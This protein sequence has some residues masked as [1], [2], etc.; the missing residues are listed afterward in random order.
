VAVD[1][2]PVPVPV[3]AS[4]VG[5]GADLVDLDRFRRVMARTPSI[6]ER[7]FTEQEQAYARSRRDPCERFGAR[8]AAKEATM[9]VLGVGLGQVRFRDL[10]VTR[11]A[12]GQPVLELHGPAAEL[13]RGQGITGWLVSLTHTAHLAQAVVV[14]LG[15][16]PP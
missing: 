3:G 2:P 5:V 14:G 1:L 13:A 8:F 11:L 10:E 6:T 4:L 9:K 12:S 16:G 7:L 15:S